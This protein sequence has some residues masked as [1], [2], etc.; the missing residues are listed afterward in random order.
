VGG[1]LVVAR[2]IMRSMGFGI[3]LN[4]HNDN[5]W[6]FQAETAPFRS[7]RFTNKFGY[8]FNQ[9]LDL[10]IAFTEWLKYIGCAT[11]EIGD[12]PSFLDYLHGYGNISIDKLELYSDNL[13]PD[14][15]DPY[16]MFQKAF[17]PLSALNTAQVNDTRLDTM[18]N[19]ALNITDDTLR[20]TIYKDIEGYTAQQGYFV[21]P[22]YH[23]KLLFAHSADLRDFPYNAFEKFQAYGIYR[24]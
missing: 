2:D 1:D 3:E 22:L 6:R 20:D 17:H 13:K 5:A 10:Y 23:P 19:L 11:E 15:P 4:L 21:I 14:Y 8:L 12:P 18:M 7:V 24:A 9:D 16:N